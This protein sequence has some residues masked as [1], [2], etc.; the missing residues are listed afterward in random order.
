[1][2]TDEVRR[3]L[4]DPQAEIVFAG[5]TQWTYPALT[6]VFVGGKVSD[7]KF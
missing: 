7:V 3:L 4:G 5:K 2:T 6:V 1:M